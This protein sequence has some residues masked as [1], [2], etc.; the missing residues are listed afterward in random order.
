[1]LTVDSWWDGFGIGLALD[2]HWIGI[3]FVWYRCFHILTYRP[4]LDKIVREDH[5]IWK[6]DIFFFGFS[7]DYE[8]WRSKKLQSQWRWSLAKFTDQSNRWRISVLA[9]MT[10]ERSSQTT[11]AL[12]FSCNIKHPLAKS[13]CNLPFPHI[14][15]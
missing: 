6:P 3:Y 4:N 14:N 9:S 1:M 12:G 2:W 5:E 7:M 11:T 15:S 13:N 10:Q 8:T